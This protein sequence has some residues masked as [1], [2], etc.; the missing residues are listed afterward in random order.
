MGEPANPAEHVAVHTVPGLLV[1]E[2]LK[3]PLRG[4]AK[5]AAAH[6]I[7]AYYISGQRTRQLAG[8]AHFRTCSVQHSAWETSFAWF[9]YFSDNMP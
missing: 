6:T 4:L 2:Q 5:G 3:A 7:A 9:L 8:R 1:E